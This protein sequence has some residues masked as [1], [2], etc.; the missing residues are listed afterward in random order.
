MIARPRLPLVRR[1]IAALGVLL[2]L[3]LTMLAVSPALHSSFHHDELSAE[4]RNHAPVEDADHACAV[5]LFAHGATGLL[6][7]CL[8]MLVRPLARGILLR[9]PDEIPLVRSRYW[10]VP[11]HAPP[12]A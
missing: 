6:L 7:F 12:L 10:L 4:T 9:A 8:L 2:V 11:S 5:T 3:W 1:L